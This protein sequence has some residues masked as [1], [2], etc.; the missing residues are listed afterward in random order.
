MKKLVTAEI[1]GNN[2]NFGI[3]IQI[4]TDMELIQETNQNSKWFELVR[5]SILFGKIP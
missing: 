3:N 4:L 2:F 1:K 5:G